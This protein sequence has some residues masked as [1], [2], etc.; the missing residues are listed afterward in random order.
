MTVYELASRLQLK[1]V[2][3]EKSMDKEVSGGYAG[4][5]L[6]NVM[7]QAASGSIWVTMQGHQN[8][9]AVAALIGLSAIIVAGGI[10]P[11]N[12]A[13]VKAEKEGMALLTTAL[14]VFE[15]VGRLHKLGIE[16]I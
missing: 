9:I 5:L 13:I 10:E 3:G 14:P 11:D 8:I 16:G 12:E 7:G 2:G 1:V 4:D 6:S 15:I